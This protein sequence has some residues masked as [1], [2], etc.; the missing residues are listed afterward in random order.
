MKITVVCFWKLEAM[1]TKRGHFPPVCWN[2]N[3]I[4]WREVWSENW[5]LSRILKTGE[6]EETVEEKRT[7]WTTKQR[8]WK[9]DAECQ[10]LKY[11]SANDSKIG[12]N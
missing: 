9:A 5:T 8:F 10:G 6:V 7:I 4:Y 11:S 12:D 2:L 3:E 1:G